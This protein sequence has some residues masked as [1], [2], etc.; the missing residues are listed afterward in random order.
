MG[1]YGS[2][3][4]TIGDHPATPCLTAVHRCLHF[5]HLPIVIKH[6]TRVDALKFG[7]LLQGAPIIDLPTIVTQ[8]AV[9]TGAPTRSLRRNK[10]V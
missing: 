6:R 8:Q 7:Q 3:Q 2:G 10:T 1:D 4:M 9:V 5:G